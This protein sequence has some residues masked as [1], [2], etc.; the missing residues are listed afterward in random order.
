MDYR[1]ESFRRRFSSAA[2]HL[3]VRADQ[4]VSLKIR[5]DVGSANAYRELVDMLQH[6]AGIHFSEV[7]IDLQDRGYMLEDEKTKML[8]VEHETGLEI[9]Y[10]AGSIASLLGMIPLVLQGWTAIRRRFPRRRASLD[11]PVE[12]RRIDQTGRL[13]EEHLHPRQL[14]ASMTPMGSLVSA[15]TT[16]G[17]LVEKEVGDL[18]RQIEDLKSR[19]DVMEKEVRRQRAAAKPKPTKPSAAQPKGKKNSKQPRKK[20]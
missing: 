20:S 1:E 17:T 4:I 10:I 15:V 7:N 3:S 13:R 18:V 12:I 9:L 19:I 8:L 6:E 14:S 11:H 5:E 16:A 2:Q